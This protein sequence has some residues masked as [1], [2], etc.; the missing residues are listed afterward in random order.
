MTENNPEI[1]SAGKSHL[2]R[3]AVRNCEGIERFGSGSQVWMESKGE[4]R[5]RK[6]WN[7]N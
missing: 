5:N 6:G 1:D 4:K 7:C 2:R 3:T